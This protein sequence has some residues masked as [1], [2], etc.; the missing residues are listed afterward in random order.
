[1][2]RKRRKKTVK[3]VVRAQ[4]KTKMS[5]S[6]TRRLRI[7]ISCVIISG[8]LSALGLVS[9]REFSVLL[10]KVVHH[11][12]SYNSE[13]I[14]RSNMQLRDIE[15]DGCNVLDRNVVKMVI[16]CS[17]G[18][19]LEE[20]DIHEIHEKLIEL[21]WIKHVEIQKV[22]PN[23]LKIKI[24][25]HNIVGVWLDD[26]KKRY[27][28][29]E[30]GG[31]ISAPENMVYEGIISYGIGAYKKLG[32]FL[33]LLSS[34]EKLFMKVKE[35]ERVGE[36]RWNVILNNGIRV[37]MPE[38]REME[39]WQYISYMNDKDLLNLGPQ[40]IDMRLKDKIF[41]KNRH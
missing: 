5:R 20:I 3:R 8:V 12:Q 6:I 22:F 2:P 29:L 38:D 26:Y 32:S 10:E 14:T 34:E 35:V 37:K 31:L 33:R 28:V 30:D 11:W 13:L 24:S 27:A 39:A 4:K 1:M 18:I 36:R 7:F 15:I 21:E 16:G 25:E 41:L 23:K 17:N 40:V 9:Y 19:A